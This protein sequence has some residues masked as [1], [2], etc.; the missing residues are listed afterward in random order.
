MSGL[1]LL[2]REALNRAHDRGLASRKV[3][4][5]VHLV[6]CAPEAGHEPGL[7]RDRGE[8]EWNGAARKT[9]DD[10]SPSIN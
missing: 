8:A 3:E 6:T 1:G 9:D 4:K 5:V 10:H 2:E 7:R